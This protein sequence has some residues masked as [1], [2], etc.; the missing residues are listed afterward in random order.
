MARAS[1]AGP[2]TAVRDVSWAPPSDRKGSPSLLVDCIGVV[3]RIALPSGKDGPEL[4]AVFPA[5][6]E[7]V[8]YAGD[9]QHPDH[10]RVLRIVA[11]LQA[12]IRRSPGEAG[13]PPQRGGLDQRGRLPRALAGQGPQGS[14][15]DRL[16]QAARARCPRPVPATSIRST[17]ISSALRCRS[18]NTA[19][20]RAP[21]A[22]RR[23]QV[24]GAVHVDHE[25]AA[26]ALH[27]AHPGPRHRCPD[28]RLHRPERLGKFRSRAV[29]AVQP[30]PAGDPPA[31]RKGQR[32][33]GD[34]ADQLQ[35]RALR[36]PRSTPPS[37][38]SCRT[39]SRRSGSIPATARSNCR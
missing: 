7:E 32:A 16:P 4:A 2:G 25:H 31:G 6:P 24:Q 10:G 8:C 9:L 37:C 15:R 18:R 20:R 1:G 14:G 34:A 3:G 27:Q 17:T 36:I 38:G 39:T 22:R 19:P 30:G 33:A 11:G 35:G 13:V 5:N 12:A 23:G 28:R 26:A 29:D 21:A